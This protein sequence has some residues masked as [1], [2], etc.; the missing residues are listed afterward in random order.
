MAAADTPD[1]GGVGLTADTHVTTV[2]WHEPR[3]VYK[4]GSRRR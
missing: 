3:A 2:E 1:L 4:T